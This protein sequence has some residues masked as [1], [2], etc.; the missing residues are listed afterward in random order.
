M[1]VGRERNKAEGL[2]SIGDGAQHLC[3]SEHGAGASQKYHFDLRSLDNGLRDR[4]QT[5]GARNHLEVGRGGLAIGKSKHGWILALEMSA[6]ITPRRAGLG[7]GAHIRH[8]YVAEWLLMED[9]E[10]AGPGW[11]RAL[12]CGFRW[13]LHT[14][15]RG[16]VS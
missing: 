15:K 11:L 13:T 6:R 2:Q 4:K 12:V 10:S 9:Y 16:C 1:I 3:A 5:P 14:Q 8:Q 7:R